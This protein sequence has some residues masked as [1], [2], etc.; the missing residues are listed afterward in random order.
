MSFQVPETL[1]TCDD[2]AM[3]KKPF[4]TGQLFQ[5]K[6]KCC[7][8]QPFLPNFLIGEILESDLKGRP[9]LEKMIQDNRFASPLGLTPSIK[10]QMAMNHRKPHDFGQR[11]DW[12]CPFFDQTFLNCGI[13]S[14]RGQSCQTFHCLSQYGKV[15]ES[16]WETL[17]EYLHF[18]EMLLSQY[19]LEQQGYSEKNLEA[20][21]SYLNRFEAN[22]E[23]LEWD[24]LPESH[25]IELWGSSPTPLEFYRQCFQSLKTLSRQDCLNYA[26]EKMHELE[27]LVQESYLTLCSLKA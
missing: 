7:T 9:Q 16:F 18:L 24:F 12:L 19:L 20:A 22:K 1:A 26:G 25:L 11:Q 13:W 21:L 15:G 4:K 17:S 2:C 14:S 6:L 27:E 8:F 5:A 23:E 10:L 3:T